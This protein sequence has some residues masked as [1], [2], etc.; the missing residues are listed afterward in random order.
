VAFSVGGRRYGFDGKIFLWFQKTLKDVN[1]DENG[2][3]FVSGRASHLPSGKMASKCKSSVPEIPGK[4]LCLLKPRN[5]ENHQQT[6]REWWWLQWRW[7]LNCATRPHHG[8]GCSRGGAYQPGIKVHAWCREMR[9]N[10]LTM[11]ESCTPLGRF[12]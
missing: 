9:R 1:L 5:P 4:L 10:Q 12:N 8:Q 11:Q 6:K 2:K 3:L 7:I